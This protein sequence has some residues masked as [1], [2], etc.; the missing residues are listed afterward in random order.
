MTVKS[1][2]W[3]YSLLAICLAHLAPELQAQERAQDRHPATILILGFDNATGQVELDTVCEA[4]PD[5]ITAFLVAGTDRIRVVDRK[6]L[7]AIYQEKSLTWQGLLG[8]R[9]RT[10]SLSQAK[11]IVR[12]S[13]IRK[14]DLGGDI[15]VKAFLHETASTRL[16]K[17]FDTQGAPSEI[18][19]LCRRIASDIAGFFQAELPRIEQLPFD[20]DPQKSLLMIHGISAFHTGRSHRAVTFFLKVLERRREDESAKFWLAQSFLAADLPS[21]AMIELEAFLELFPK[22]HRTQEVKRLLRSMEKR[23]EKGP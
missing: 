2:S 6:V 7:A 22:S 20:D 1:R 8:D 15:E 16:I 3:I 11:Y 5:L 14:G 9:S 23:R 18:M 21:H 19:S 4:V 13:L 17:A 10:G 12:G